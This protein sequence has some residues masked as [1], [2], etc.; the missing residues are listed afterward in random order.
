FL[1]TRAMPL[2]TQMPQEEEHGFDETLREWALME[3]VTLKFYAESEQDAEETTATP[4]ADHDSVANGEGQTLQQEAAS[5]DSNKKTKREFEVEA[6]FLLSSPAFRSFV[7]H[8]Q[9]KTIYLPDDDPDEFEMVLKF[10]TH[11]RELPEIDPEKLVMLYG[12]YDKYEI[13][14]LKPYL[15]K[16]ILQT[17]IRRKADWD[18]LLTAHSLDMTDAV[19]DQVQMF[20]ANEITDWSRCYGQPSLTRLVL[21]RVIT[22]TMGCQK[23]GRNNVTWTKGFPRH[24]CAQCS[25]R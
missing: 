11:A 16:F 21:E 19:E 24:T 12:W 3:R 6:R 9:N 2:L 25:G 15:E 8:C 22:H 5:L 14:P 23:C 1:S 10:M 7:R 13:R 20:L 17:Q 18:V 4:E